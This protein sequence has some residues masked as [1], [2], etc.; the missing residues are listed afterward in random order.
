M[1]RIKNVVAEYK[2]LCLKIP[3]VRLATNKNS[4]TNYKPGKVTGNIP[5][6]KLNLL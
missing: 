5:A 6:L 2:Q 1:L 3:F 4:V